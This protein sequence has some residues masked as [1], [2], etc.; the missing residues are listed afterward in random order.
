ML[1]CQDFYLKFLDNIF[2][3]TVMKERLRTLRVEFGLTQKK[4]AEIIHSTDKNIWA[5][6]NGIATP[7]LETIK[8]YADYFDVTTDY[9]LGRTEDSDEI[10]N[11]KSTNL[12]TTKEQL[13]MANYRK[14][15]AQTQDYIFGIV[16]NL[17]LN[18]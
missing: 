11:L 12:Y 4:L 7:P 9:I 8:A 16:Q 1:D 17:A 3:K 6:E 2:M 5:Y 13:L 14:L 10:L 15:P 18:S